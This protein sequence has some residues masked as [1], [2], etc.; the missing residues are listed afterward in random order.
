MRLRPATLLAVSLLASGLLSAAP[1]ARPNVLMV[2]VDDLNLTLGTYGSKT[3]RSPN[4]DRLAARGVRF[5]SAHAQY[6]L[7]NPSRVSFLSGRRPETSGV[8]ILGTPARTALPEAVMLPQLFRQNGYF[9]AGAEIG[10]A[11]V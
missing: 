9:T 6:T 2:V 8:Y 3:V 11:H 1:A 4:I 7:C 10:R 5:D